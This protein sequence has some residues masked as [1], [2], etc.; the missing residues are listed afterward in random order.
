MKLYIDKVLHIS[1][2][3]YLR[4]CTLSTFPFWSIFNWDQNFDAINLCLVYES[5]FEFVYTTYLC[6]FKSLRL[7]AARANSVIIR[8]W[9][10][11]CRIEFSCNRYYSSLLQVWSCNRIVRVLSYLGNTNTLSFKLYLYIHIKRKTL[12]YKVLFTKM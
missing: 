11:I 6:Q 9:S 12:F 4:S 5:S 7:H 1:K 10:I 8:S 3:S 2:I